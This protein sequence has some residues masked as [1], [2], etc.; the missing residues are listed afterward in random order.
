VSW[1]KQESI[2]N[3]QGR[4]IMASLT[5]IGMAFV[6][7]M[8]VASQ[9]FAQSRSS[10]LDMD[11]LVK[12]Y[13]LAWR[14][15]DPVKREKLLAKVWAPDGVYLSSQ[16]EVKGRQKLGEYMGLVWQIAPSHR[17]I[18]TST[19]EIHHSTFR[20]AWRAVLPDGTLVDEGMDFGEIDKNGRI[21]RLVVFFGPSNPKTGE[22]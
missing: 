15:A 11:A 14:E 10:V 22:K 6:T 20:Y 9:S 7:C 12:D 1:K 3:I 16:T 13:F 21:R 8:L 17:V 4:N 19:V 18:E 2:G 5:R